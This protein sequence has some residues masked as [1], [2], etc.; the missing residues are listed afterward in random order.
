MQHLKHAI[1][2]LTALTV[3]IA[4]LA[5]SSCSDDFWTLKYKITYSTEHGI[6]PAGNRS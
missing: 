6:T 3:S 2:L 4:V 5:L 1:R